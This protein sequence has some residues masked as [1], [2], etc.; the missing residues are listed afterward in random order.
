MS[1]LP[2]AAMPSWRQRLEQLAALL[3]VSTLRLAGWLVGLA[4]AVLGLVVFF[5][6]TNASARPEIT[7]PRAV[8]TPATTAPT[9][10]APTSTVPEA[11]SEV[12][13]HT[14]GAV[15]RPGVHRLAA[16]ARVS[17]ALVAA[18]GPTAEAEVDRLNLA[19]KVGDGERVYVVRRGE[20]PPPEVAGGTGTAG[21]G[22]SAGR[23]GQGDPGGTGPGAG[24]GT[25]DLNRAS[26]EEL[27]QLPGIGP[28]TASAIVDHRTNQGPFRTVEDLL[29]VRGIG[30][31]KLAALRS[32]VTVS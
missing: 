30:D 23:K 14:A 4:V 17:D 6:A 10:T 18:G 3:G 8:P 22:A 5:K 21:A 24:P 11:P 27:E 13:V 7:L 1:D 16:G 26:P 29:E 31:A 32:Q 28:A 2:P 19:A 15:V 12:V 20:E 9:T 25:V